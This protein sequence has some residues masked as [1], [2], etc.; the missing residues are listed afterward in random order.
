MIPSPRFPNRGEIARGVTSCEVKLNA[1]SSIHRSRHGIGFMSRKS[2]WTLGLVHPVVRFF[3]VTPDTILKVSTT[4]LRL[5]TEL[6]RQRHGQIDLASRGK[7]IATTEQYGRQ[8][9]YMRHS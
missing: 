6:P 7:M 1:L 2:Q 9:S 3:S 5:V 8:F 4:N